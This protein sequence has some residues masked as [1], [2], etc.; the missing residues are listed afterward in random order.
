MQ[1][2]VATYDAEKGEAVVLAVNRSATEALGLDAVV[3]GLGS[4]RVVEAITYANKDPYCQA[5]ADDSTS[6]ASR[7]S[8]PQCPG[9]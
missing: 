9:R 2:A 1:L 3:S 8:S 4:V 7:P 6:D 5:T